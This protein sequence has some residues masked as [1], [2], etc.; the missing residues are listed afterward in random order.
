MGRVMALIKKDMERKTRDLLDERDYGAGEY[1]QRGWRAS[2]LSR[3]RWCRH[4]VI[5]FRDM[6]LGWGASWEL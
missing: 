4:V 5:T 1:S 3:F 2:L 6:F